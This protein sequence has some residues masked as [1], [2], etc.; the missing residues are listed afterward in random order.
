MCLFIYLSA[1]IC[2]NHVAFDWVDVSNDIKNNYAL[3]Q[4]TSDQM[5]I[6]FLETQYYHANFFLK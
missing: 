4:M 1:Q 3:P 5:C 2:I 6:L